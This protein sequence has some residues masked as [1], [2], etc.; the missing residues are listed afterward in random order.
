[1][2]ALV[3]NFC[4]KRL[5]GT[6]E[7]VQWFLIHSGS[8]FSSSSS[9]FLSFSSFEFLWVFLT[10]VEVFILF[11]E[12]VQLLITFPKFSGVFWVFSFFLH[13]Y[14]FSQFSGF[15]VGILNGFQYFWAPLSLPFFFLWNVQILCHFS[16]NSSFSHLPFIAFDPF[17]P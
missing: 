4:I 10:S 17:P 5:F 8:D 14:A 13:F 12:F 3:F 1:M 15:F 11:L 16:F 7:H 6:L 2:S 9:N